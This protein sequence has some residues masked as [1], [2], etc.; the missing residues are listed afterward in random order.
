MASLLLSDLFGF[1]QE[2]LS[3]V[4]IRF[5]VWEQSVDY[6][7]FYYLSDKERVNSWNIFWTPESKNYFRVG[8]IVINTIKV[9]HDKW[10]VTTV[11]EITEQL[12]VSSGKTYEGKVVECFSP[13][14]D[15]LIIK[16]KPGI[17]TVR[18]FDRCASEIEVVELL[19]E[20]FSDLDFPGYDWVCLP[21]EKLQLI[22]KNEMKDW[23][24][25]LSNQKAVYLLTD[26]KT[27]KGY[28]GSATSENGMLLKRWQDYIYTGHGGNK[29]LR[30][31]VR[32]QGVDYIKKYFQFSILENYNAKVADNDVIAREQWWKEVLKTRDFGYNDN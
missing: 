3:K 9:G 8:E 12:P 15:R 26:T 17:S 2:E 13:Y 6:T 1:E 23:L 14:F 18:Y 31:L 16:F 28:V 27:G 25:A 10:L 7:R 4:K 22:L 11:K 5:H 20:P 30:C 19:A 32:E 24:T 29:D 21:F